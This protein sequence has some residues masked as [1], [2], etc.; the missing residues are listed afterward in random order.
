[1][2]LGKD[3]RE[4]IDIVLSHLHLV[5][6]EGVGLFTQIWDPEC[7]VHLWGPASPNKTLRERIVTYFSPPLF[8]VHLDDIPARCVF[9]DVPETEWELGTALLRGAPITHPGPTLGYRIEENS[10]ILAY[11]SDHEPALGIDLD[12]ASPE[13]VSGYSLARGADVLFHDSQYTEDEYPQRVGWGH[14]SVA[15][16]VTFGLLAKVRHL[17]MF[18]HDP[19]HS[20]DQLESML[21]RAHEL[22]GPENDSLTLSYEGMDVEVG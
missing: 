22:W 20:D 17:L 13:W 12:T 9:H 19:L 8:P 2:S 4:L 21:V 16:T 7:E 14:S 3:R 6:I 11:L 10:K 15:H 18:H 1:V 5:H